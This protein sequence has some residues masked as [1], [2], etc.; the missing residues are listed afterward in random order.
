MTLNGRLQ[1]KMNADF[2]KL[3]G[4]DESSCPER[5]DTK[6]WLGALV[7]P[8]LFRVF[9]LWMPATT[10][11]DDGNCFGP[12]RVFGRFLYIPRGVICSVTLSIISFR[13]RE[14]YSAA[15]LVT[16]IPSIVAP[17]L[18]LVGFAGV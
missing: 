12:G 11:G 3:T 6:Y 10:C 18:Y 14:K 7:F 17:L 2:E 4:A 8:A 9:G 1:R 16:F 15:T 5:A 13:K